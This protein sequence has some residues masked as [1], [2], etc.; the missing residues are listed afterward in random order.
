VEHAINMSLQKDVYG[1]K[2][3]FAGHNAATH[4]DDMT[5]Y[6]MTGQVFPKKSCHSGSK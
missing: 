1:G 3:R 2:S 4:V 5:G 6:A